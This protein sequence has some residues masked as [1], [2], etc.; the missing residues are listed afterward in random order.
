[1]C[2]NNLPMHR[3]ALFENSTQSRLSTPS[4]PAVSVPMSKR[5]KDA[6]IAL[7]G[8]LKTN[9]SLE[10]LIDLLEKPAGGFMTEAE[11]MS[12]CEQPKQREKVG[13]IITILRRKGDQ[14]FDIF[15]KLLRESGNEVWAEQL[16]RKS[17]SGGWG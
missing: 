2:V 9:L 10:E 1:M 11:K 8:K 7:E 15:I 17:K 12:V 14:D 5:K 6:L 4:R 16:E 13:R 3:E